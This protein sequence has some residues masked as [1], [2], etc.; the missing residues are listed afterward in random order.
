M[1]QEPRKLHGLSVR[2]LHLRGLHAVVA[3]GQLDDPAGAVA[4][5][6]VVPQGQVLERFHEPAR[7]VPSLRRLHRGVDEALAAGHRVEEELGGSHPAEERVCDETLRRRGLLAAFEVRQRTLR[8]SIRGS[9]SPHG[10]LPD[11]RHHLRDVDGGSLAAAERHDEWGVVARELVEAHVPGGFSHR[12]ENSEHLR[13]EGLLG[14]APRLQRERAPLESLDALVAGAVA[15]VD[16][17]ALLVLQPV[18]RGDVVDADGEAAGAEPPRGELRHPVHA[19]RR[20][21]AAVLAVEDVKQAVLVTA[22]QRRLAELPAHDLRVLYAHVAVPRAHVPRVPFAVVLLRD[23]QVDENPVDSPGADQDAEQLFPRP[24]LHGLD[25]RGR[26]QI[27]R[28][29]GVAHVRD[30]R[31]NLRSIQ[32]VIA[33]REDVRRCEKILR[34]GD[35]NLAIL[36]RAQVAVDAHEVDRLRPRLLRLRAVNV[37]LV[38]VKVRVVRGA[39]ALVETKRSPRHDPSSVRHDGH[40]VQRGLAVEQQ[41]VAVVQVPLN[42][43]TVLELAGD[44]PAVAVLEVLGPAGFESHKVCPG[45]L[46][47]PVANALANHLDVVSGHNLRVG[48]HLRDVHRHPDLVDAQVGIGR[49]DRAAAK[50]DALTG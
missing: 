47:H 11:A 43:V 13:L 32:K 10:L 12:G 45:V 3:V 38:A 50:V 24:Q 4:H 16:H 36:G 34:R 15:A 9:R 29:E 28:H 26:G 7:H 19:R 5:G 2:A 31:A 42:H 17:L 46:V 21:L 6:A 23:F 48:H 27:D 1:L 20:L 44:A 33:R 14:V 30:E 35:Q 18:P 25:D 41:H 40:L 8:E 22:A 39:H 37:H 49:D